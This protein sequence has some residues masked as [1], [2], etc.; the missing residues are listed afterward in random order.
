MTM[1][2]GLMNAAHADGSVHTVSMDIDQEVW[3]LKIVPDQSDPVDEGDG[4]RPI[5]TNHVRHRDCRER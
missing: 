5:Y 2:P 4:A 1:H 3:L